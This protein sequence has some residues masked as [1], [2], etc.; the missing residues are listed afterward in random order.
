[1]RLYS[2]EAVPPF[3]MTFGVSSGTSLI[4]SASIWTY[5][6]R[7][8]FV[9]SAGPRM[10]CCTLSTICAAGATAASGTPAAGANASAAAEGW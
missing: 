10:S 2:K 9:M 5:T 3:M 6:D 4:C 1:M 8:V 7:S